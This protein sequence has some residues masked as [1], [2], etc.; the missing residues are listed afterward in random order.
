VTSP[1]DQEQYWANIQQ[2]YR[3]ISVREFSELFK[4][5]HVGAAMLQELSV[6]FPKDKSHRAALA[7]K[8][9]AVSRTELFK[10]S[11]A[12]EWVLY[13]RNAIITIFKTMQVCINYSNQL[14]EGYKSCCQIRS[15]TYVCPIYQ[16]L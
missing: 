6:P 10:A 8:T 15:L 3:Y 11:F 5:F 7:K 14:I 16:F 13:K 2:P 4:N 9:Y 12:K 1:K